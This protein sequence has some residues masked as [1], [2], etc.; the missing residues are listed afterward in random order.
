MKQPSNRPGITHLILKSKLKIA[1]LGGGSWGTALIKILTQNKRNVGW[2]IRNP[3]NVDFVKK[4]GHNPNYLS[5]ANLKIKRLKISSW[6][7]R[8]PHQNLS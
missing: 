6:Y 8:N 2:Y 5:A 3:I 4:H 7:Q 1:V